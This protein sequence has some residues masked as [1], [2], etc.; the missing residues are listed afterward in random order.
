VIS[1]RKHASNR[2]NARRSTG[3]RSAAAKARTARNAFRHGLAIPLTR[4]PAASAETQ[5]LAAALVG[6]SSSSY[7][8][9]Q[10]RVAAEAELELRRVRAHRKA[11]LDRKA[12]ELATQRPV[13]ADELSA[14]A[15]LGGEPEATAIAAALPDLAT[16]ERY[17]RRARSRLRR[18]MRW[19]VHTSILEDRP[20]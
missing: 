11:L 15:E 6:L 2:R 3:P 7:R 13:R 14:P 18:A 1:D 9:E 20:G 8:L 17:E 10:A 16:L 12:A 5:R 4:D 19:L